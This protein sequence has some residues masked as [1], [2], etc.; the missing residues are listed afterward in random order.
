[1]VQSKAS[2]LQDQQ[3]QHLSSIVHPSKNWK[4]FCKSKTSESFSI[5]PFR[6]D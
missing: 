4:M 1:M 5:M 3:Q 2:L 6:P